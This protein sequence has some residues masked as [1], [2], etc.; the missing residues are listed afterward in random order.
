[1]DWTK[2]GDI[3]VCKTR[4]G[5]FSITGK[6]NGYKCWCRELLIISDVQT[7]DQCQL[8]C[9]DYYIDFLGAELA[10]LTIE[11]KKWNQ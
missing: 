1:M 8:I 3:L 9:L 11:R 5:V 2:L 4:I 10:Q 7:I 6:E